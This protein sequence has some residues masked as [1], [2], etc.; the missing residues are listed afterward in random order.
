MENIS[1]EIQG[2]SLSFWISIFAALLQIAGYVYYGVAMFK[3]E[4]KPSPAAWFLWAIGNGIDLYSYAVVVEDWVK[5]FLPIA[6]AVSAIGI[7]VLALRFG[8]MEMP[9]K[10]DCTLILVDLIIVALASFFDQDRIGHLLV[11]ADT[12][13]VYIF[14]VRDCNKDAESE[15]ATPWVL[16]FSAYSMMLLTVILRYDDWWG[17]VYP[18][19]N[20][21]MCGM[22]LAIVLGHRRFKN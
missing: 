13:L 2:D 8:K 4:N 1:S 10:F 6:C 15:T 3:G 5:N 11:C 12:V 22:I 18:V 20:A 14:V 16:W 7:F 17:L 19:I 9:S 21:L